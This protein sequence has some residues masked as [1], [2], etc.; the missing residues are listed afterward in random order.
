M[1]AARY[2]GEIHGGYGWLEEYVS[3]QLYRDA[4]VLIPSAGTSEIMRIV[5][6]RAALRG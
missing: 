1:T 3:Q 6:G 5:A 2:C 4:A